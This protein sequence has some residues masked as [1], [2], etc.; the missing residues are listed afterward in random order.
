L[1]K[2]QDWA[3]AIKPPPSN[4]LRQRQAARVLHPAPLRDQ[5]MSQ[6]PTQRMLAAERLMAGS[7]VFD[8]ALHSVYKC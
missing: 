8:F 1:T 5:F 4:I 3:A 7:P 2:Q 6:N